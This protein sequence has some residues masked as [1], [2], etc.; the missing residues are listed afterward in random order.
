MY[1]NNDDDNNNNTNND[2]KIPGNF[3]VLKGAL[4]SRRA[5]VPGFE[6]LDSKFRRS[7]LRELTASEICIYIYIYVNIYI[8]CT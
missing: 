4:R 3:E 7:K 1:N 8:Y 5:T 2:D 6:N